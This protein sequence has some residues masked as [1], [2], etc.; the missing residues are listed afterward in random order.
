M[1]TEIIQFANKLVVP[2]PFTHID[3]VFDNLWGEDFEKI[4]DESNKLRRTPAFA[5]SCS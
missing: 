3:D 1:I 4:Y 2:G 5:T